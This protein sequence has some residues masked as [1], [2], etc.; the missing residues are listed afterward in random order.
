M[1][2]PLVGRK[3]A[4]TSLREVVARAIDFQAPQLVTIVGNQGTGKT[5]LID[6]LI[7]ELREKRRRRVFHGAAERDRPASSCARRDRVAACVSGSS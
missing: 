7:T 4:L 3:D 1:R 5:R 2:S 6:E